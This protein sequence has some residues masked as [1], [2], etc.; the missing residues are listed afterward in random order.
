MDVA[1]DSFWALYLCY[2][3]QQLRKQSLDGGSVFSPTFLTILLW[4]ELHNNSSVS[5][6]TPVFVVSEREKKMKLSI[7][8]VLSVEMIF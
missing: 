1:E 5:S 3:C 2:L 4:S 7:L 8:V 6:L